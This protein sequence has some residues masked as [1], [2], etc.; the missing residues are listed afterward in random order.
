[1][2]R[3][4]LIEAMALVLFNRMRLRRKMHPVDH[5]GA[6]NT[7]ECNECRAEA[8]ASLDALRTARPDIA[9]VID[10]KAEVMPVEELAVARIE[11]LEEAEKVARRRVNE[12]AFT[13]E[14][15]VASDVAREIADA[16]N[17]LWRLRRS[18]SHEL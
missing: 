17:G 15:K 12:V 13:R 16:I 10:G 4:V 3:D 18:P 8:T 6:N 2:S 14:Q 1:M 9:D 5:I 11:A 7:P